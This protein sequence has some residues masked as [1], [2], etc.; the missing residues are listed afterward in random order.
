MGGDVAAGCAT[1]YC[2]DTPNQKGG[3]AGGTNGLNYGCPTHP[4][5]AAG[6]CAGTTAEMFMNFMDYTDDPCMY[7]F[8][9]DQT[10]RIQTAMANGTY[11]SLLSASS[12]TLCTVVAAAPTASFSMLGAGCTN[13][14]VSV[15]NLTNGTPA[16]T[17]V[18]SSNPSAGVTFNPNN[19]A[20]AP[21]INFTTPGTYSISVVATN[22][23]GSNSNG[24]S[25]VI[26]SCTTAA[27]GCN[28]T[29]MNVNNT[30]TL[31]AY[32]L[33]PV[34]ATLSGYVGGNNSYGDKEKAEYFSSTGLVGNAQVS[35]GI[36][37]FYKNPTTN[38]GTKGTGNVVFKLYN[39]NNTTGPSGPAINSFTASITSILAST[40]PTNHVSYCANPAISYTSNIMRPYTFSFPTPSSI[41]GD[42]L[43]SVQ[44]PTAA[45]DTA[46]IFVTGENSRTASTGWELQTPSTWVPFN[47]NTSTS[48]LLNASLA[49]LPK[50][51]CLV[52]GIDNNSVLETNVSLHPNPSTGIINI[53]ATLSNSQ[54]LEVSVHNSLGQLVTSSK[55]N[56][57]T[58]NEFKMDLSNYS[59]GV[60]FVTIN[61]GQEKIV[62]R[63][64]LNK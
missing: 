27:Q 32:A 3:F 40:T 54:T 24:H 8:T 16:P 49:I 10:T 34:S 12:A 60:Y 42:F 21:T 45:G 56:N 38:Y 11:R 47:D 53:V 63:L 13:S 37:I 50:I 7:M 64:I 43:I 36:V 28:D 2:N 9:N 23:L 33:S 31:F 58:S 59:N 48:W 18:W 19:T 1:D 41:T 52:T 25:I 30:D 5:V 15:T 51:S 20:T 4:Y 44:L 35:G 61:N 39:G 6:E 22:S 57:V 46:A 26:S 55:Y 14:A 62:K 17:Y 29:L